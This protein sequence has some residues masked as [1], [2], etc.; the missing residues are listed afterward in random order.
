MKFQQYVTDYLS[1]QVE[2]GSVACLIDHTSKYSDEAL[3]DTK[4]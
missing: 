1:S 4:L 3:L 2:E